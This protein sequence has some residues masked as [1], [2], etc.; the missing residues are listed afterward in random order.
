M[1][2][3]KIRSVVLGFFILLLS[4]PTN[5][6]KVDFAR[7]V[8]P[9]F[10]TACYQCHG[11]DKQKGKLR[12]DAKTLA[13]HGGKSGKSIVPGQAEQSEVLKGITSKDDDQRM[14]QD[15]EPLKPEQ[16]AII[17][18]WIEQG[19]NWPDEASAADAKIEKHWALIPPK[20]VEPPSVAKS[21]WVRNDVD[22][23]IL[24]RLEKEQITPSPEAT[25][26][27]LLRR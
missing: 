15:R 11:P 10:K 25:K 4:S 12:L 5:A 26:V 14:P 20:R 27:Q 17:N 24:A 2:A 6:Q 7:D 1:A 8:Q 13:L 18:A 3:G 9:I 19:A 22:R 16:I 23:F 21:D